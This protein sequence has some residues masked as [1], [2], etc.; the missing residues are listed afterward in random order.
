[1]DRP[2]TYTEI[3]KKCDISSSS[4]GI[5][6]FVGSTPQQ[7]YGWKLHVSSIQCEVVSLLTKILPPLVN[8]GVSFKIA[9][10]PEVLAM[11]NEGSYGAT[12]VG[13]FMTIYPGSNDECLN[14]AKD[15]INKTKDHNGP[16]I[17]TDLYLGGTV[18]SRFGNFNSK[19]SRDRLGNINVNGTNPDAGYKVPFTIPTGIENPFNSL[20][21]ET[22]TKIDG[23]GQLIGPGYLLT[24]PLNVHAK[25][26]V[27]KAL[28]CRSQDNIRFVL[29][30]EGRKYC[31]SDMQGRHIFD[32]LLHQ[33]KMHNKLGNK[34]PVP[35][36]LDKFEFAGNLYIALSYIEGT[37]FEQRFPEPFSILSK[38]KKITRLTELKKLVK[39]IKILHAEG[40]IHRDISPRNVRV[41]ANGDIYLLDFELSYDINGDTDL[42]FEQGTPGYISPQQKE[43]RQP[44]FKDDIYSL[45][46]LM[47]MVITGFDS[48]RTIFSFTGYSTTV[49]KIKKLSGSPSI[50]CSV[51]A[52][53]LDANPERR[54]TLSQ[55]S[56]ALNRSIAITDHG[57]EDSTTKKENLANREHLVH[58]SLNWIH[59]PQSRELHSNLWFSPEI[60]SSGHNNS[61]NLSPTFK[62][63]R[64]TSR[65]V[66]GV[67]YT[68]SRLHKMGY[69]HE[70]TEKKVN[71]TVDWLLNHA[72]T[73]DDQMPGLHFG[74]A[75]VAVA[76]AEAVNAGL[77]EK[78]E[79]LL[80]YMNE[81]LSARPDWP[82]I[83]H[84]A[85]GQGV[86]AILCG[87]LLND[88]SLTDHAHQYKKYLIEK[89]LK[90]GSWRL[91]KGVE[92]MEGSIYTGFAHGVAGIVYFLSKYAL[93]FKDATARNAAIAGGKWLLSNKFDIEKNPPIIN[94]PLLFKG[95]ESWKWWCHGGPGI[96]ISFLSL[97]ELTKNKKYLDVVSHALK[98]HPFSIRYNNLSQCHGLSGLAEIYLDAFRITREQEYYNRAEYIATLLESLVRIDLDGASWLVENTFKP[99]ADLMIGGGGV[100]HFLA[101]FYNLPRFDMGMPLLIY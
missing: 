82:D 24:K 35:Q 6:E 40:I 56:N 99:T 33:E 12:Q 98:I 43:G 97:F 62:L 25:G 77:I 93:L 37:D 16:K 86:A 5:W 54:P 66:S 55:I 23:G 36:F 79:W 91:P 8:Y 58:Q 49:K 65:G 46:S 101:R 31:V 75:G 73:P 44:G 72:P 1:M 14:I 53:C 18:Y 13:K 19:L 52:K 42:P 11:L 7:E 63:Y 3:L 9:R 83:T 80:P 20:Q 27:F 84:G 41:T 68:L 21:L 95:K 29:L 50:L 60:E 38:E 85:A 89:Q 26:T 17:I 28:D 69:C 81:T 4:R 45:G 10:T 76:I 96:S 51:I 67:L 71:R 64:S 47:L 48:Q 15:L 94:W 30:K 34:I 90:D 70:E 61:N 39:L 100:T 88:D 2:A 78:G 92:A 22:G 57:Y 87:K 32:R 59:S 74:E